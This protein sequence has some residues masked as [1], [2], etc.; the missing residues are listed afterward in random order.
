MANEKTL[1]LK[2]HW[3]CLLACVLVSMS[4]FQYGMDFSLI[5]SM[6]AMIGFLKVRLPNSLLREWS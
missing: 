4:P 1:G 6:Q 5:G 3:K 2:A